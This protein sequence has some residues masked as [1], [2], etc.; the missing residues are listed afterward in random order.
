MLVLAIVKLA[1]IGTL[2]GQPLRGGRVAVM[3]M[4]LAALLAGPT[5]FRWMDDGELTPRFFYAAWWGIGLVIPL[6]QLMNGRAAAMVTTPWA[7][8]TMAIYTALPWLSLVLHL[9][10]LHYV[11]NVTFYSADAAPLL[12][13][14]TLVLHRAEPAWR[15]GK[16]GWLMPAT[17]FRVLRV[18]LPAT[19]VLVSLNNPPLLWVALDTAGAL[20]ITPMRLA[21]AG[22]YLTYVYCLALPYAAYFLSAGAAAALGW[23][24]GPTYDQIQQVAGRLWDWLNV[25]IGWLIPETAA[26]W[27]ATAIAAAFAFLGVGAAVSLAKRNPPPELPPQLPGDAAPASTPPG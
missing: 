2:L 26:Q 20:L 11:Y 4:Q 6:I 21:L 16:A 1:V 9:S 12:L 5:V 27:G 24:F 17:D 10:I 3:A 25:A 23:M 19:A 7:R 22:A 15:T 18:I 13:G 14:L 8:R